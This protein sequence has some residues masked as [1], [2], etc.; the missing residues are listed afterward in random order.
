MT[1]GKYEITDV[2]KMFDTSSKYGWINII[3]TIEYR[4][5]YWYFWEI[6][7]KFLKWSKRIEVTDTNWNKQ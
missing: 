2:T 4:H 6:E 7:V 5:K 3:P 1:L